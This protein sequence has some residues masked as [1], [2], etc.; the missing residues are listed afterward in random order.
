MGT[1]GLVGPIGVYTAM[2]GSPAM[3]LAILLVC[4]VLPAVLTWIFGEIL[5]R[6]HWINP[7][8]LKLDL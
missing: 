7:G 6:L 3:W 2:D 5:R 1:C 8:D 4:F